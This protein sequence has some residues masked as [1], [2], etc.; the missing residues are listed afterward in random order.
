MDELASEFLG[1]TVD[2]LTELDALML[3]LEASPSN[4]DA[5]RD[6]FRILHTIK[7]TCGFL[8]FE[9]L[10]RL[11]HAT[12]N[13]FSKLRDE[14]GTATPPVIQLIFRALDEVRKIIQ[15]LQDEGAEGQENQEILDLLKK[16]M[17]D[18]AAPSEVDMT[19]KPE[20][21]DVVAEGTHTETKQPVTDLSEDAIEADH[22]YVEA[23]TTS[24]QDVIPQEHSTPPLNETQLSQAAITE[25]LIAQ[26]DTATQEQIDHPEPEKPVIKEGVVPNIGAVIDADPTSVVKDTSADKKAQAPAIIQSTRINLDL[27]DH[28]MTL[29]SELVLSR[30]QLLQL[31][32]E[33]PNNIFSNALQHF[34]QL[35]SELQ[36]QVMRMRMQPIQGAWSSFPRMIRDLCRD[37]GKKVDFVQEGGNTDVDRQVLDV[38]KDPLMHIVRNA[39]DHGIES[40][41][42]RLNTG[43]N[44][45]GTITVNS[46]HEEGKVV[47]QV[48]DDG[49]GLD[50]S[51]LRQKIVEKG[52]LAA[53]DA[54]K[55]E[56]E[57]IFQYIF[58]PGFSTAQKISNVSGR[59]VGMDVVKTNIE[60][61]GGSVE[62]SSILHKGT[63]ITIR[64]PLTLTII[65]C[66]LV[67]VADQRF[68]VPQSSILELVLISPHSQ[69]QMEYINNSPFLRLRE[70]LLPLVFAKDIF[71]LS[72]SSE[73]HPTNFYVLACKI[74]G[75]I[76]GIVVERVF[77]TQEIV[78]KPLP[79]KIDNKLF[80]GS[81]IL[82]DGSVVMIID[83]TNIH[84][85]YMKNYTELEQKP[86]VNEKIKNSTSNKTLLLIF[87]VGG[88]R[89]AIPLALVN[90]IDEVYLPDI[91]TIDQQ[92]MIRYRSSLL[93][94]VYFDDYVENLVNVTPPSTEYGIDENDG[95]SDLDDRSESKDTLPILIFSDRGRSV[96]IVIEEIISIVEDELNV[97]V[98]MSQQQG[99]GTSIIN[100]EPT[101]IIDC[102]PYLKKIYQDWDN[103]DV[104][105]D[106]SSKEEKTLL[107]TSES[108]FLIHYLT[109]ILK[110]EGYKVL[111]AS[112]T[113]KM[114]DIFS[115]YTTGIQSILIDVETINTPQDDT[116]QRLKSLAQKELKIFAILGE[117][118]TQDELEEFDGYVSKTDHEELLHLLS[119]KHHE[120]SK[121]NKLQQNTDQE[122]PL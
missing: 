15:N 51:V 34:S 116:V 95:P 50:A 68:A 49:K 117:N 10:Q 75:M 86:T 3:T 73:S 109:P 108:N 94:I 112:N 20:E 74:G 92:L 36:E 93:P 69:H 96:G 35:T 98:R 38:I 24:S 99:L 91:Q 22:L 77:D 54:E 122:V 9:N 11:A 2:S 101:T 119:F 8:G 67:E 100:K 26:S 82:G 60:K 39:V 1:E 59:G 25:G 81:T 30:N 58:M 104:M 6:I 105:S 90:R 16:A 110:I 42:V 87:R 85:H 76:F 79:S 23:V 84:Q 64:I 107:I 18:L 13:I 97:S 72:S 19:N 111:T 33:N 45:N 40:P 78:V 7:G 29:V 103:Q 48:C 113:S 43:K 31:N 106:L 80:S 89:K 55:L 14:K 32:I 121:K 41:D 53:E 83:P 12:E 52:L 102:G 21:Q 120:G 5:I 44:E 17:D 114:M 4:E 37:L 66:L 27:I 28:L 57:E 46:F 118:D 71:Q 88:E 115:A 56:N 70:K 65:S 61:M 63:T 47:I 62:L